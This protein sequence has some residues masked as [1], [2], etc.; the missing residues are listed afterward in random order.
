MLP[1]AGFVAR[2]AGGARDRSIDYIET[3]WVD[4]TGTYEAYWQSR[5]KNL[6]Q[7]LSKQRRRLETEG[8]KLSLEE[9][10]EPQAVVRGLAAYGALESAGW[11]SANGTAISPDN[12]QGRFYRA[13]LESF[14]ARG[15]GRIYLYRFD[16]RI[17]AVDLCIEEG[18]TQVI[19]KTT[20][21]ET[22]K[23][24][25]PAFLM[26]QDTF[27]RTWAA[28]RITQIE[29]YGKRMEWHTRWTDAVRVLY[30]YNAYRWDWIAKW[31]AKRLAAPAENPN[32][33]TV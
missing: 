11:K 20:Y 26:R 29:F 23:A 31:H 15:A 21:D 1:Y 10:C 33:A 14:C 16:D 19:L 22:N 30:H 28:N 2:P 24:V 12:A 6:R 9:I 7:N 27:E 8:V 4:V 17:V 3:A 5:G 32:L 25:S 18:A 13:M